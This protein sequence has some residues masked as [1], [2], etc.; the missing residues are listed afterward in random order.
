MQVSS[1]Y[2]DLNYKLFAFAED[3][4]RVAHVSVTCRSTKMEPEEVEKLNFLTRSNSQVMSKAAVNQSGSDFTLYL[5]HNRK[6]RTHKDFHL[7]VFCKEICKS[8]GYLIDESIGYGTYGKV[9]RAVNVDNV[10]DRKTVAIKVM[11][12]SFLSKQYKYKFLGREVSALLTIAPHPNVVQIFD[13]FKCSST[14]QDGTPPC[15]L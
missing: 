11:D 13:V 2:V 12:K 15:K 6:A 10:G 1:Q 7:P 3:N 9:Y 14:F 5:G 8:K 4:A